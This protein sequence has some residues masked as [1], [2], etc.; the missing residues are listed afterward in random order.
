MTSNPTEL[1][2]QLVARGYH[3][4]PNIAKTP[5]VKGW[6][7]PDFVMR[8]LFG[9]RADLSRWELRWPGA[10]TIGVRVDEMV[11]IDA[12]IDD[13]LVATFMEAVQHFAPEIYATAPV[14]F[15]ARPYKRAIFWRLADREGARRHIV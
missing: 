15:G 8:E 11:V 10:H 4:I 6:N 12:D 1:R 9:P 2:T 3:V 14:R 7:T 5:A 13:P